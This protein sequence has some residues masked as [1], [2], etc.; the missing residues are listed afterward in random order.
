M[1]AQDA[2]ATGLGEVDELYARLREASDPLEK[3]NLVELRE[4][5]S[6]ALNCSDG[7]KERPPL[8][9]EHEELFDW[10]DKQNVTTAEQSK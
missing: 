8:A 10:K 2:G 7:T 4:M 5:F 1:G 6:N 9:H 3:L